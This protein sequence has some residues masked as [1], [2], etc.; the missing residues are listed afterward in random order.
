MFFLQKKKKKNKEKC[1]CKL[2]QTY[3]KMFVTFDFSRT[4]VRLAVVFCL[5]I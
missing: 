1:P 5:E 2:C 4:F 3:T